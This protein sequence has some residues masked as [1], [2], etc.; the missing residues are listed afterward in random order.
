M[1]KTLISLALMACL[2]TM[3]ARAEVPLPIYPE[4]GTPQRPDLCPVDLGINWEWISY[5]PE[6]WASHVREAEIEMGTGVHVDR[7]WARTVGEF[8]AIIA[9]TDAGMQWHQDNLLNK[10]FLNAGEL[11]YP[12]DAN[13]GEVGA[14]DLNGDGVFNLED[15]VDDPRLDYEA[16]VADGDHMLDPSDLI[17][18]VFGPEWDGVDN[19]GNGYIDD[20]SGWDFFW[21]DNDAY[22]ETDFGHGY[23]A[24]RHAAA[25]GGD[26]G[27]IGA[28]PNCAV[29]ALRVSDSFI[30][31]ANHWAQA[32]LYAADMGVTSMASIGATMNNSTFV[33]QAMD[34]AW[35]HGVTVCGSAADE[36]AFHPMLPAA[37]PH[38]L[39][40]NNVRPNA[41]EE[42]DAESFLQMAN[43]TNYGTRTDITVSATGCSSRALATLAGIAGLVGSAAL[44]ADEGEAIDP[45]AH[46]TRLA[47]RIISGAPSR[48]VRRPA[49]T[50]DGMNTRRATWSAKSTMTA[51]S[52][53]DTTNTARE[54]CPTSTRAR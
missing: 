34:Y 44:V 24:L 51:P 21:N 19:D 20:I 23:W 48:A 27:S 6:E 4:C 35:Y 31:D 12:Q 18:G 32:L 3:S 50:S 9:G 43:C 45:D 17:H 5:V 1:N 7:A 52:G 26:G 47:T 22:D 42:E 53:M 37:N 29:M 25:E 41:A 38:N 30:S 8:E 11:P 28:C 15:W 16:G 40:V 13:G 36:A 54:S 33:R 46:S 2:A 14:H 39:Y 10:H 49:G